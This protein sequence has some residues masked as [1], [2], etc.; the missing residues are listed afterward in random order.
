VQVGSPVKGNRDAS[1][2]SGLA[3][4]DALDDEEQFSDSSATVSKAPSATSVGKS[5]PA[6][7]KKGGNADW[8]KDETEALLGYLDDNFR[9]WSS[10]KKIIFYQKA[11]DSGQLPGRDIEQ[12][13]NKVNKLR[14]KYLDEKVKVNSTGA[15]PSKWQWYD[16]M[17]DI[18]GHRENVKPSCIISAT[19]P[20]EVKDSDDESDKEEISEKVVHRKKRKLNPASM[21]CDAIAA[22]GE[23]RNQVWDK[24]MALKDQQ[25]KDKVEIERMKTEY[26]FKL[27]QQELDIEKIKAENEQRRLDLE[28]EKLRGTSFMSED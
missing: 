8:D 18:F 24:K 27:K 12:I 4:L 28:M 3:P 17:D 19:K 13:K 1:A 11:A 15:E 9:H 2:L 23:S 22:L 16:K 21:L 5:I 26:E 14:K 7:A 25:R 20:V 6:S 10:G